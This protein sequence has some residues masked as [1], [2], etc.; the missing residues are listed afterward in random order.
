MVV[1]ITDPTQ[2]SVAVGA[3]SMLAEHSPVIVGNVA[4]LA[5]GA[6]T[7]FTITVCV[8]VDVLPLPSLYVQV[9]V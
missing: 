4:L 1:P 8:W 2:L 5:A 6:V 7:S 9:T 3:V